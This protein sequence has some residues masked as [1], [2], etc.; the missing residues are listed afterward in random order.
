[1]IRIPYFFATFWQTGHGSIFRSF[2]PCPTLAITIVLMFLPYLDISR[3]SA[4]F[5]VPLRP[6]PV[7]LT[8]SQ[9]ECLL[10]MCPKIFPFLS[11]QTALTL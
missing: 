9:L 3:R 7:L 8:T 4:C 6:V 11:K 1:M 10:V 2:P 5:A